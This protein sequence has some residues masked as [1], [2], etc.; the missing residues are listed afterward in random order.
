[1]QQAAAE[2]QRRSV[3]A[4][5]APHSSPA[6]TWGLP[7]CRDGDHG[8]RGR[9]EWPAASQGPA[10]RRGACCLLR[11]HVGPSPAALCGPPIATPVAPIAGTS[12]HSI[13]SRCPDQQHNQTSV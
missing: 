9:V 3:R 1:M 10:I 12:T 6:A 13:P 5:A 2:L 7:S 8:D 11:L 4:G